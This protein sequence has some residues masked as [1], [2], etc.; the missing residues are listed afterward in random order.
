MKIDHNSKL[1][2]IQPVS[3]STPENKEPQSAAVNTTVNTTVSASQVSAFSKVVEQT[4]QSLSEQDAVD[5]DKVSKLRQAIA[6]GEL[7]LDED[8]LVSTILDMHKK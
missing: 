6:N 2:Q 3:R 1:Q 4:Y 5:M 8:A 7:V